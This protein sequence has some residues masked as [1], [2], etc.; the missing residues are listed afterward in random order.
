MVRP[1]RFEL[2]TLWFEGKYFACKSVTCGKL[3]INKYT[4]NTG[5]YEGGCYFTPVVS[6]RQLWPRTFRQGP[7]LALVLPR[8]PSYGVATAGVCGACTLFTRS[9]TA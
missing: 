8:P 9:E 3:G 5:E 7:R 1:E 6:L 2:P 4:E